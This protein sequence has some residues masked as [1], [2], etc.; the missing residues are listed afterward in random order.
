MRGQFDPR[1]TISAPR[2]TLKTSRRPFSWQEADTMVLLPTELLARAC[3]TFLRLAYPGGP[4][5]IPPKKRAYDALDAGRQATDYLPP[6]DVAEGVV[7][8]ISAH[9]NSAI[10]WAF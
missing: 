10:G 1:L 7:Q 8:P 5:T 2:G 6:A 3:R 4:A 9:G